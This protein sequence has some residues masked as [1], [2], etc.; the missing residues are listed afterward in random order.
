MTLI[1]QNRHEKMVLSKDSRWDRIRKRYSSSST[2]PLNSDAIRRFIDKDF[3]GKH[4]ESILKG[5]IG[6]RSRLDPLLVMDIRHKVFQDIPKRP[7]QI[8]A[9]RSLETCRA[10]NAAVEEHY[11]DNELKKYRQQ[12][13]RQ[14]QLTSIPKSVKTKADSFIADSA[15]IERRS[16]TGSWDIEDFR[17]TPLKSFKKVNIVSKNFS[18]TFIAQTNFNGAGYTGRESKISKSNS[19]CTKNQV[20]TITSLNENSCSNDASNINP[21]S[22]SLS[23]NCKIAETRNTNNEIT[24]EDIHK[25]NSVPINEITATPPTTEQH[26]K[27]NSLIKEANN[28]VSKT[29]VNKNT[30]SLPIYHND[31]DLTDINVINEMHINKPT[32]KDHNIHTKTLSS[33]PDWERDVMCGRCVK[34]EDQDWRRSYISEKIHHSDSGDDIDSVISDLAEEALKE[35][36]SEESLKATQHNA[37]VDEKNEVTLDL[38]IRAEQIPVSQPTCVTDMLIIKRLEATTTCAKEDIEEFEL[39]SS[40]DL[41]TTSSTQEQNLII[42]QLFQVRAKR[43]IKTLRKYFLKWIHFTTIEKIERENVI[44]NN[45]RVRKINL[46]LDQIRKVKSRPL[47]NNRICKDNEGSENEPTDGENE[48]EHNVVDVHKK[49]FDNIYATKKYQNKIKIQQDIIDLQKLK[50]EKQERLIMQLKV[51]NFTKEAQ[52]ARQDIKNEL[53]AVLKSGD[54]KSKAKAKCLQ[55]I[56]N[57]Q[58]SDD[59]SNLARLRGKAMLLPKFLQNMQERA[60]ERSVK[61]EQARQR[62]LQKEAER[63]AQKAALEEAKRLEDEEAKRMRIEA[64]REKR[65]QE[66]MAKIIKERERQRAIENNRKAQEFHRILL[67]RRVGMEGFKRLIQLKHTYIRKCEVLKRNIFK[68]NYFWAWRDFY[69]T[70]RTQ[71][72]ERADALHD[73]ILKRNAIHA[74]KEYVHEE[75]KKYQTAIDWYDLKLTESV[76]QTWFTYTKKMKTI[77]NMKMEKAKLHYE[78]HT[79]WKVI[80]CWR[81]LPHILCLE[82]ETEERRQRWR[83]KIWELLPDYVPLNRN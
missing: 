10:H 42:T 69:V 15:V 6:Q 12:L 31:G 33:L 27:E 70:Q 59:E 41:E 62:R 83:M 35:L 16:S 19:D 34:F 61:H 60:L 72:I 65:R 47:R 71:N 75:R 36:Q 5:E 55:I 14:Y 46:F 11:L 3:I 74:W 63:E 9:S 39:T 40:E 78:W 24:T 22:A 48:R 8:V 1:K 53:K 66:K 23:K 43:D 28:T 13:E 18:E 67:L 82:R 77:E 81:R 76:F 25:A 38:K 37:D 26:N 56:G 29:E 32:V 30:A 52:E 49:K 51:N 7:A 17:L 4:N 45:N 68:R 20:Q 2:V 64:L 21:K 73:V 79:R 54:P 50:L 44:S 80:D 57:L 58:D